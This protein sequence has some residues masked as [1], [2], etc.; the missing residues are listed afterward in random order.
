MGRA[1][2]SFWVRQAANIV[3]LMGNIDYKEN[4]DGRNAH[5]SGNGVVGLV[6]NKN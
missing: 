4:T 6:G 2:E 3:D 5:V 1:Y